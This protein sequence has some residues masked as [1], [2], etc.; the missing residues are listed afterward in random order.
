[1]NSIPQAN[2][3]KATEHK[4][5]PV[6]PTP[7]S[8]KEHGSRY[9]RQS[10]DSCEYRNIVFVIDSSGSIGVENFNRV[11]RVL[12]DL[13]SL[14]CLPV[15]VA[16]MTFD[17]EYYMEFCFDEYDGMGLITART[18]IQSVPYRR[19]HWG[20]GTRWTHTAGAAR[21]VC[22]Y[23]LTPTCG[24]DPA[25]GC[26]DVIFFTDGGANDPTLDVCEEIQC[27]HQ[28][29]GVDTFAIGVGNHQQLRL[30]CYA[31]HSLALDDYHLFNFDD[32]DEL[33]EQFHL[34]IERLQQPFA[35]NS[36]SPYLCADIN[37]DPTLPTET[38]TSTPGD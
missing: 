25:A 16:V 2:K 1:M 26:I 13:T 35:T 22:D 3:Q 10:P 24:L 8:I 20:P 38:S 19:P 4:P 31:N 6:D 36:S 11:T 30:G 17:H 23:V 14:F 34:V 7:F 9:R 5:L 18:H 21:C 37:T 29:R 33:E 15:K 27:L 12:G 28:R 32:F